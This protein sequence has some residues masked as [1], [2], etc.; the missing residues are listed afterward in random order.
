MSWDNYGKEKDQWHVD[1]IVPCVNPLN[2]YHLRMCFNW[3]NLRPLWGKDNL[4][5]AAKFDLQAWHDLAAAVFNCSGEF[6][7]LLPGRRPLAA[8]LTEKVKPGCRKLNNKQ[9]A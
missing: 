2:I 4:K 9:S 1:H 3:R 7:N 5:K 6:S 8:G